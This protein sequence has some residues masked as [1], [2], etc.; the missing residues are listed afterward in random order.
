TT[1]YDYSLSGVSNGTY[2]ILSILYPGT[3]E[4]GG[5]PPSGS[6][7]GIYSDGLLPGAWGGSGTPQPV[8]FE[9]TPLTGLDFH[10]NDSWPVFG[11]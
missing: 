6:Q 9:G 8:T 11:P 5:P 3:T 4:A 2:Y 1:T 10:L 7:C